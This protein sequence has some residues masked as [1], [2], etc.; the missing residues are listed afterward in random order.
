MFM[1]Q[2]L[3]IKYTLGLYTIC[4]YGPDCTPKVKFLD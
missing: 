2:Y 1:S 3:P 4:A